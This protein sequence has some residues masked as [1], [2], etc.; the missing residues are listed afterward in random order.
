MIAKCLVSAV[1]MMLSP[2]AW[3][4]DV[5]FTVDRAESVLAVVTHKGGM[6]ARFA[7]NHFVYP[8]EYECT[9]GSGAGTIEG[10]SF[11]L[12]FKT[13]N[14]VTDLPDAQKKWYPELEKCGVLTTPFREISES[15]RTTIREHMLAPDQLDA[16][17]HPSIAAELTGLRRESSTLGKET[18]DW[19]AKVAMTVRG[20]RVEHEIPARITLE[21]GLLTIQAVGAFRF[22]E[23]GIEPYSAMMGAVKNL[24]EFHVFAHIVARAGAD[25]KAPE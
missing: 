25:R 14:L 20:K 15:S 11:S 2:L 13:A 16:G 24:D 23:F 9:I 3:T 4:Q 22:T 21:E 8:T 17:E 5:Q 19:K 7:H 10:L 1:L 18:F 12:S 6:G